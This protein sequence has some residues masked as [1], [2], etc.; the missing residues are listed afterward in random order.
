VSRY[1]R[2][3]QTIPTYTHRHQY[4]IK[5]VKDILHKNNLTIAR[6]DKNKATVIIQTDILEQ[7]INTFREENHVTLKKRFYRNL[8]E[9]NTTGSSNM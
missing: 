8:S 9:T 6:A 2:K 5:Q 4:N 7:K 3:P 1:Q